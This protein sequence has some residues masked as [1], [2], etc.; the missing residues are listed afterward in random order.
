MRSIY[1]WQGKIEANGEAL[2]LF[3]LPAERYA[4]FEKKLKSLHPY[5]VPEIIAVDLALLLGKLLC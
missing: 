4:E 2:A 3:K 1:R 5:D